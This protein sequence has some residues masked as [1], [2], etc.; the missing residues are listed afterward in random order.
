MHTYV[1]IKGYEHYFLLLSKD[2]LSN[3]DTEYLQ[4]RHLEVV[5]WDMYHRKG[6]PNSGIRPDWIHRVR[7]AAEYPI[8]YGEALERYSQIVVN[9][10]GGYQ[11]L[12][13]LEV[14]NIIYQDVLQWPSQNTDIVIMENQIYPE[15]KWLEYLTLNFPTK[16]IKTVSHT[17]LLSTEQIKAEISRAKIISFST[18]FTDY[19]WL[20]NTLLAANPN[21]KIIGYCGDK[22]RWDEFPEELKTLSLLFDFTKLTSLGKIDPNY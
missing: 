4:E 6:D 11:P 15:P 20:I 17:H 3:T 19:Q 1:K 13:G 16:T 2:T 14:E 7:F 9:H 10:A 5:K 21:Q 8:D 22:T 18:T 12:R